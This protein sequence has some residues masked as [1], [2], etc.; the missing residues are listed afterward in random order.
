MKTVY[1]QYK[2]PAQGPER[3]IY[4]DMAYVIFIHFPVKYKA[5]CT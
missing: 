1:K 2:F 4:L 5:L 3:Q